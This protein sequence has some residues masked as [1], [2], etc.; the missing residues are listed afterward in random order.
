MPRHAGG[1]ARTSRRARAT[2]LAGVA[3]ACVIALPLAVAC[4]GRD[5]GRRHASAGPD[6]L[7]PVSAPEGRA[8]PSP[9]EGDAPAGDD[10][11]D[12]DALDGNAP[13]RTPEAD[14]APPG[15]HLS[16]ALRC[17]PSLS[18]P[19]GVEA[20]TCVAVQGKDVWARTYYRNTTGAPL[21]AALSLLGPDGHSVRSRCV[22]GT[23]D[24]PSLC[25]T[26]RV[27]LNGEP[28]RY[29]AVAEFAA[30]AGGAGDGRLLLRAGSNSP[31]AGD[32]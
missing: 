20:Q 30:H 18:S 25:E 23:G 12:G 14:Q 9:S 10:S 27:R 4:A 28:V 15:A 1:R 32:R 5:D 24:D 13:V 8:S 22:A 2:A 11:P 17:G 7:R 19:D 29:T 21:D 16:T 6:D 26:P 31:P 3:A